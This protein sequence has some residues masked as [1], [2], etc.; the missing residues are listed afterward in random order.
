MYVLHVPAD[1]ARTYIEE[2][3]LP[4]AV[5]TYLLLYVRTYYTYLVLVYLVM[6]VRTY[7]TYCC[8]YSDVRTYPPYVLLTNAVSTH[9]LHK[10]AV[11]L[12]I[13]RRI[14]K[15]EKLY[16]LLYVPTA[17][18]TADECIHIPLYVLPVPTSSTY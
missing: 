8:F 2:E 1:D 16:L 6:N 10:T 12:P 4:A 11:L 13:R 9:L 15:K 3:K 17:E 5:S 18:R 14:K 7:C